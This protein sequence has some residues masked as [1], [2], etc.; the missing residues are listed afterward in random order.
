MHFNILILDDEK[1]VCNSIKRILE[2]KEKTVFVSQDYK[3]AK[4]ILQSKQIDL[5]LL[6][7]KLGES[8]GISVLRDL[9][10]ENP[11]L[12]VIMITAF[13]NIEIA[14]EAMKLGAYDF[15]QKKE[16]PAFIRF[17]VQRALDTL[18]L[19]K[20]VNEL[21]LSCI[22]EER[23]PE[24]IS[25]SSQMKKLLA[26]SREYAVSD[27]TVLITGETGTGKNL[28]AQFIHLNSDR[29]GK[30]FVS[31]NCAAIPHELLESELFGYE[32]GAFTGARAAGKPGLLE[33]ANGGTLFLDEISDLDHDLQGKLLHVLEQSEFFRIG[34]LN[35]TK[36]DVRFIA[37]TN[38]N[39]QEKVEQ[40]EFRIDLYYRLN[41][42]NLSI[43]PLRERTDD[44]VPL[45]K[46]FIEE[47]NRKFNK[48]VNAISEEAQEM[49][50]S[51]PWTGNIRELRNM[52]ERAMLLKK[53]NT[54]EL[55]DFQGP[56]MM[57]EKLLQPTDA[58]FTVQLNPQNGE[59]LFH[60]SQR[61]LIV[62][63]LQI[64]NRNRSKAAQLLGIPRTS[65]NFYM[66]KYNIGM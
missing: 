21:R 25:A 6:D 63:A 7:Y 8:D 28:L 51:M 54:L 24:I 57:R 33:Q 10:E 47:F 5:V 46:Y 66:K 55:S 9:K 52:I 42:A 64:T 45:A 12:M 41:V 61:Q 20:E 11:A 4:S 18:R 39:L 50:V 16:E 34:A 17:T 15:I 22:R 27:T 19:R 14:V 58:L 3:T 23:V 35:P 29:F 36:V 13:G 60:Q 44:I 40:K 43:P 38:S 49:L 65:L 37:A 56:V 26:L 31:I 48:S 30:A 1:L 2:D 32:R 59:N 53:N 62:Q